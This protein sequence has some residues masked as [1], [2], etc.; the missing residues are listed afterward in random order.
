[1]ERRAGRA[2]QRGARAG[3]S[4]GGE[5]VSNRWILV[6]GYNLLHAWARFATRKAR[7]LSLHQR[8][9]ALVGLLRQY[10]DHSRRRVTVVFDGYAAKHTPEQQE[11]VHGVEGLF[12]ERGKKIG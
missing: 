4:V 10:A 6:D 3:I 7:Q 8:R 12:S 9:E 11:P 1:M 2:R 5:S